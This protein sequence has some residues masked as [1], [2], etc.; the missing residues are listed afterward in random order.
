MPFCFVSAVRTYILRVWLNRRLIMVLFP[1]NAKSLVQ[2]VDKLCSPPWKNRTKHKVIETGN[3]MQR[4]DRGYHFRMTS[5]YLS[6]RPHFLWVYRFVTT[7]EQNHTF[8]S[9]TILTKEIWGQE[10][11]NFLRIYSMYL[12]SACM[13][14][15]VVPLSIKQKKI[16][17]YANSTC[18]MMYAI[19]YAKH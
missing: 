2:A 18:M 13:L 16:M 9:N 17:I 14:W 6:K 7:L 1:S 5:L 3:Q 11:F 19:I 4:R 10:Q 12:H 8:L 15:Y